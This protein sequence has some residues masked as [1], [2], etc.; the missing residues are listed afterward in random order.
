M[1]LLVTELAP[2]GCV[3]LPT[4]P[5]GALHARCDGLGAP[6]WRSTRRRQDHSSPAR[7]LS[8]AGGGDRGDLGYGKSRCCTSAADAIATRRCASM[9]RSRSRSCRRRRSA[10]SCTAAARQEFDFAVPR[11]AQPLLPYRKASEGVIPSM[12]RPATRAAR[13][14]PPAGG[15]YRAL[16]VARAVPG[17][18][19]SRGARSSSRSSLAGPASAG[20]NICAPTPGA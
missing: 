14:V 2:R 19:P 1:R 4:P 6:P 12:M 3:L 10:S 18:V 15:R 7:P 17:S 16:H 9:S 8:D 13:I 20:H 5:Y 11:R